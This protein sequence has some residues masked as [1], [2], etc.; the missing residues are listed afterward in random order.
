MKDFVVDKTVMITKEEYRIFDHD[1]AIVTLDPGCIWN[2]LKK[3]GDTIGITFAGPSRFAVDA[4]VET[5]DGVVGESKSGDLKGIQIYIGNREI[6]SVSSPLSQGDAESI[7]YTGLEGYLTAVQERLDEFTTD[8]KNTKIENNRDKNP[9]FF[10]NDI[11]EKGI[12]LIGNKDGFIF[13]YDGNVSIIG[14]GSHVSV[15]KGRISIGGRKGKRIVIDKG[16]ISGLSDELEDLGDHLGQIGDFVSRRVGQ[17]LQSSVHRSCGPN[18]YYRP[19]ART[20]A[21]H[22]TQYDN[23]DD[24]DWKD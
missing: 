21:Y 5:G 15:D 6:Y 18:R 2:F 17:A 13:T 12:V 23:V 3:D 1:Q 20:H 8:G 9:M 22:G 4:I 24:F 16:R 19:R 14:E 11:D 10:G 7:G